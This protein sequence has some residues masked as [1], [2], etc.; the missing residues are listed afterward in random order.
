MSTGIDEISLPGT[1]VFPEGITADPDGVTF[2]VSSSRDGTIFR[3]RVGEPT[4]SV[5]LAPGADGRTAALGMAVD[6]HG[7]LLI[8]GYNT[9]HIFAYNTAAGTLAA[10]RTVP[11]E[12][13]LLNDVCVAG[14]HAYVTDSTRPVVWRVSL[15]DE[16]GE[17]EEWIDLAAFGAP[18]DASFLNGIIPAVGGS[19][20]L[21]SAQQAEVLWR[22]D[23]ATRT[24]E[25]VD[26]GS[27]RV[28]ADGP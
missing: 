11:T 24:A 4:A 22:V 5:W 13:A 18:P 19:V 1:A 12:Q 8:C 14:H 25:P 21:V 27:D 15:G 28:A 3:G 26:L 7:R 20:L 23:I 6:D 17:P 2:W 10:R 9:R 16:I